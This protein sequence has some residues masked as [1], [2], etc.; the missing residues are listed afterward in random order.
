M[1]GQPQPQ[2]HPLFRADEPVIQSHP[3]L[4]G[5]VSPVFGRTDRWD[6][7]GVIRRPANQDRASWRILFHGF[8]ETW[9][10]RAREMRCRTAFLISHTHT[11]DSPE[12]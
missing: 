9:S 3:L 4:P 6:F 2:P 5:A 12:P 7:N 11:G 10:L 1:T 8:D